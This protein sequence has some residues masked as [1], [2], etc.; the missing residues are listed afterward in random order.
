[1]DY[2]AP[3]VMSSEVR[4]Q[5]RGSWRVRKVGEKSLAGLPRGTRDNATAGAAAHH[6]IHKPA[7]GARERVVVDSQYRQAEQ[8]VHKELEVGV[9]RGAGTCRGLQRYIAPCVAARGCRSA[10]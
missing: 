10:C 2:R 8:Q 9:Q 5:Y 6:H 3:H 4:M 1:M 7:V